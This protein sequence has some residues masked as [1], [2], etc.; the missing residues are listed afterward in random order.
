MIS[1]MLL[2]GI[3]LAL[4]GV[5]LVYFDITQRRLPNVLTLPSIALT[6]VADVVGLWI[7]PNRALSS[8]GLG[9]LVFLVCMGL[10]RLGALGMGDAKL[11][12]GVALV[13]GWF[14]FWFVLAV[15][16]VPVLVALVFTLLSLTARRFGYFSYSVP[17]GVWVIPAY[18]VCLL[19]AVR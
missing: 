15:L 13:L 8:L 19:I 3:Y 18:F 11:W 1:L 2:P 6:L 14:S 10:N 12:A 7:E 9:V 5:A 17:L 4:A 16:I